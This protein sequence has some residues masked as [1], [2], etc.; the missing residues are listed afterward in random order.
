M[1]RK[2]TDPTVYIVETLDRKDVAFIG[3]NNVGLLFEKDSFRGFYSPAGGGM[4][5]PNVL[6][7]Y[8]SQGLDCAFSDGNIWVYYELGAQVPSMQQNLE[9]VLDS[10]KRKLTRLPSEREGHLE[11][12]FNDLV[13]LP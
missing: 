7:S 12:I 6:P 3:L 9:F 8:L 13:T 1:Y 5:F 10:I 2:V 11:F 4:V